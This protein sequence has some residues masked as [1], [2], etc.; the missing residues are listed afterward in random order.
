ME[1]RAESLN[2]IYSLKSS[3]KDR[4]EVRALKEVSFEIASGEV[5]GL[6]G[7]NGAGKSTLIKILCGVLEPTSGKLSMFCDGRERTGDERK[8]RTAVLF[9]HRGQLW[10][11]LYVED[12]FSLLREIYDVPAEKYRER[13]SILDELLELRPFLSR[14]LRQLSLGQRM[15]CEI[16]AVFLG[17][18]KLLLL[19]E[20][21]LGLDILSKEK[22]FGAIRYFHEVDRSTILFT[23]H[24]LKDID[25]MCERLL[26]LNEG[27]LCFDGA[28][29]V[30]KNTYAD[31][32]ILCA[33]N[34]KREF[35]EGGGGRFE[36]R[37]LRRY[38]EK[39]DMFFVI[40]KEELGRF[41]YF[42][43]LEEELRPDYFEL[44]PLRFEQIIKDI[45]E[46]NHESSNRS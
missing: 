3:K 46:G 18:P 37:I 5:C 40:P 22:I 43:S 42:M 30:L 17:F 14:P 25:E 26:I 24:D 12:S 29:Q 36:G 11:D 8:E 45:Y 41:N 4:Q 9:G 19:D 2:K 7:L 35:A 28:T 39:N 1:I 44:G 31:E 6:I 34:V 16:A 10:N 38:R 23:S 20:A 27:E 15:K 21:T 33:K 13:L 32:Y